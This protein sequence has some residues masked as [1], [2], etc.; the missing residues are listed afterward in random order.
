M[1]AN[2]TNKRE[3]LQGSYNNI[4]ITTFNNWGISYIVGLMI[5]FKT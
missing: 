3:R 2:V 5:L 4:I 1:Q